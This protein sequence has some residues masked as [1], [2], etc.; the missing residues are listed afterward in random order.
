MKSRKITAA[1]LSAVM[2]VPAAGCKNS[3]SGETDGTLKITWWS[4]LWPHISQTAQNFGDVPF[5]QE[6]E[7]RCNVDL[8]F[9]HPATGQENEKFN[10]LCAS[11][12]YPDL[13][14]WDFTTYKGGP[15]KAVEDGVIIYL[16]EY[17]EYAPNYKKFL[18][19]NPDIAKQVMTDDGHYY[20]FAWFRG[21]DSLMCWKGPQIRAD[22]LEKAGL[23]MPETLAEWDT[24]L[25]KFKDMGIEYPLSAVGNA[26]A[27]T[28][29]GIFGVAESFY[30]E[31]GVVKYGVI[32][33]AYKD[34]INQLR[35]WYNDGILDQDFYAQD[36]KTYRAKITSGKVG[37]YVGSAGGDMGTF[38]KAL[39]SVDPAI[40]L[41]GTKYP[42]KNAGDVPRFGQKDFAYYPATSISISSQCE[43]IEEVVKFLDYGYS[44]E[45]H[46]FYNFGTEGVS[47]TMVDGFP[48]YTDLMLNNPDGLAP[49]FALSLHTAVA[50]GGPFIQDA[51]Y[52]GQYLP[53]E[54]QKVAVENW[55]DHDDS[56]R[57]PYISYTL[58]ENSERSK[59]LTPIASYVKENLLK[60]ITGQEPM[61]NWDAFVAQ[62]KDSGIDKVISITQTALDRYNNR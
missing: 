19:E 56:T 31:D 36:D 13:I 2:L 4:R 7:K 30:Q 3:D 50:Y 21:D 25:R 22:L 42:V 41:A 9:L 43:N 29:S 17:L 53:Y 49:Q 10:V 27:D 23:E 16:D 1:L 44:E 26:F 55:A 6:L 57:I 39:E 59:V 12:E 48:T 52:Y 58:D 18:D 35:I 28:F 51:R 61:E 20:T 15:S 14:E 34:Y 38:I 24:A 40:K 46:M 47:Y 54:E 5:Y 32:E 8:E 45:G 33:P 37:A 60:F 11:G 62:I